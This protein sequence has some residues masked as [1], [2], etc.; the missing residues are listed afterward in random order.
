M[1]SELNLSQHQYSVIITY[2]LHWKTTYVS[3]VLSET[4]LVNVDKAISPL[5]SENVI[6]NNL[7]FSGKLGKEV[8]EL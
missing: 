6:I 2:H 1:N 8:K 3:S 5:T 7:N 4:F